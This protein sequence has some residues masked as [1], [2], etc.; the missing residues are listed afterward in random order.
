MV[1]CTIV[2]NFL[3][4]YNPN[5]HNPL[6]KYLIIYYA[7]VICV[8]GH[9]QKQSPGWSINRMQYALYT[10]NEPSAKHK[11][12]VKLEYYA[13]I[14]SGG[15]VNMVEI[16]NR[17]NTKTY[18][19]YTLPLTDRETLAQVFTIHQKL[20][21]FIARH[22]LAPGE[23]YAGQYDYVWIEY[24]NGKT[25][26]LSFVKPFMYT[27]FNNIFSV[28]EDVFYG[29]KRQLTNQ[30]FAILATFSKT[31]LHSYKTSKSLPTITYPGDF[32][33]GAQ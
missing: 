7:C 13:S 16:N 24:S 18:L 22:N 32:T 6:I 8:T 27:K 5:M 12:E 14:D 25:D 30:K 3:A 28:L 17:L 10:V 2:N 19:T 21:T 29:S 1:P 31:L 4:I 23:G 33:E 20:N 11:N 9:A 26:E 15:V